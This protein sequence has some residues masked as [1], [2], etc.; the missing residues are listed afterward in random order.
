[1][2]NLKLNLNLTLT[3]SWLY[4]KW[5]WIS[6]INNEPKELFYI[7]LYGILIDTQLFSFNKY[8]CTYIITN[9]KASIKNFQVDYCL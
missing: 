5:F 7:S 4:V 1:M 3:P 6:I 8:E 9:R 2:K